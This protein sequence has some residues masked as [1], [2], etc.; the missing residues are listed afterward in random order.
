MEQ[1]TQDIQVMTCTPETF[2]VGLDF[3]EENKAIR[4]ISIYQKED[5]D[6]GLNGGHSISNQIFL[7]RWNGW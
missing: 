2:Y 3:L 1:V 7:K 5:A 4:C 6:P